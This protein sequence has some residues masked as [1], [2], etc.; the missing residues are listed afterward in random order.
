MILPILSVITLA[1][2][3]CE[4][5][6][7]AFLM[8]DHSLVRQKGPFLGADLRC[9]QRRAEG[10]SRARSGTG[11]ARSAASTARTNPLTRPS[12]RLN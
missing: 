3:G 10:G 7:S 12:T 9:G 11:A 5:R 2:R 8:T 6:K 1:N 4:R